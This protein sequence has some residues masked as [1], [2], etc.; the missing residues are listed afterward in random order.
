M[1]VIQLPLLPPRMYLINSIYDTFVTIHGTPHAR[2]R[3]YHIRVVN[4]S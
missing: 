4:D 3:Q 2:R 1:V